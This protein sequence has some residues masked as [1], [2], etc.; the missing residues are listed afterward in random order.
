MQAAEITL[1]QA[2]RVVGVV[3]KQ[4]AVFQTRVPD[5]PA[6]MRWLKAVEASADGGEGFSDLAKAVTANPELSNHTVALVVYLTKHFGE[7]DS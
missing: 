3:H 4:L 1:D 2:L 7:G 5:A 6:F